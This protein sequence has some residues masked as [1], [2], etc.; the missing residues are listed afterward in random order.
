MPEDR[1]DKLKP[2][3]VGWHPRLAETK[4]AVSAA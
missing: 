3:G 4:R 1:P 2:S